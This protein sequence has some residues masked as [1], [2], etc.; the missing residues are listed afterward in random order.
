M[1]GP[2]DGSLKRLVDEAREDFVQWLVRMRGTWKRFLP[3]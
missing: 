3:I 1:P 2:W